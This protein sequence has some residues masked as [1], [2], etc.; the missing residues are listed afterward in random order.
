MKT[1]H[2]HDLWDTPDNARLTTKQFSFRFPVHIGAKISA[3]CEMYPQKNR[4]QIVADLLTAALDDLEKNLPEELGYLPDDEEQYN[5]RMTAEES[6][7][8]YVPYY[9]LGGAR[10]RF[11]NLAN[12]HY[13]E[14]E[15]ELGNESP[16][17]LYKQIWVSEASMK[18]KKS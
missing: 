4:T 18:A 7:Q 15:K 13:V 17:P 3:L 2:L 12:Q 16:T 5:D 1:A 8:E 10:G 9:T 11:R 6:G 14:L